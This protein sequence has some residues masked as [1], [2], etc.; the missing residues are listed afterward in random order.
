MA[1]HLVTVRFGLLCDQVRREDN[2]KLLLIGVF[3][4]DIRVAS[5]PARLA[6]TLVIGISSKSSVDDHSIE[7]K[8]S[9]NGRQVHTGSGRITISE[10]GA[11]LIVVPNIVIQL[12]QP[13]ELEFK[14]KLGEG[15]WNTAATI[16]VRGKA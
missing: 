6:L 16:P 11:E 13:G 15:R 3:G 7:V 8:T 10:S 2:G 9:F 5:L 1:E 4:H 12:E 14:V